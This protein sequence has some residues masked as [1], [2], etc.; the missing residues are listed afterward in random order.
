MVGLGLLLGMAGEMLG[1]SEFAGVN[2]AR[3]VIHR[4]VT[5]PGRLAADRSVK[6]QARVSGYVKSIAVDQGDAV[7]AGQLLCVIEVPELEAE[8]AKARIEWDAAEVEWKRLKEARE[9][10]PDLVLP[11]SVDNAEARVMQAKASLARSET[12]LGFA[13]IRA[14]F[15]GQVTQRWVDAGAFLAAGGDPV[16]RV[17]DS[18]K[19][20]CQVAVTEWEV[21]WVAV[22]K[23][24][25][26]LV[27][28]LGAPALEAVISR[29]GVALD[30]STRTLPVEVDL[31][32]PG[33]RLV[34]GMSVTVQIGV[35]RHENAVLVP[36][37]AVVMEKTQGFVFKAVGGKAVKTPVKIGFRDAASVEVPELS[38][39]DVVLVVGTAV[40]ADGQ[41]V[42]VRTARPE[43]SK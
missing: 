15:A 4:W 11:Q 1:V 40:V 35:E 3:G 2:P 28:A 16:L 21:P 13:Q 7:T 33:G 25:K 36:V 23:P 42:K 24:V 17:V 26:V 18:S 10:S 8:R 34:A 43:G 31:P 20:R 22:G 5:L 9:K 19:V 30:A 12:L 41:E 6:L 29:A 27:D 14:P 32:N 37:E 38:A 39:E